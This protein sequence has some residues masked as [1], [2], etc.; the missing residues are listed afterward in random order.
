MDLGGDGEWLQLRRGGRRTLAATGSSGN[1]EGGDG[2]GGGSLLRR[3]GRG[4]LA[5]MESDGDG[6]G[7][8]GESS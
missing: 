6:E 2:E 1:R 8:D 3:G 4:A 5:A 7:C